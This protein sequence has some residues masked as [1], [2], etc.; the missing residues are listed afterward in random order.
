MESI[1]LSLDLEEHLKKWFGYNAFRAFQKEIVEKILQQKDVLAILPT[2]A[3]KSI[4]YQLPALL[5]EGTAIVI[6][7]LIS[8]MQDQVSALIKNGIPATYINSSLP[9]SEMH[10]ILRNLTSYKLVYIAPER[11][12]DPNFLERLK[13][14]PISFF[15]IDEAHCISQWGHAFRPDYRQLSL[16]KKTFPDKPMMALT[17]TA[18]LEVEKDLIMQLM[19]SD[20]Y[21]AKGSFDRPNLTIR[22]TEKTRAHQ[23][24]KEFLKNHKNQSGIIY[25]AT[26]KSVDSLYEELKGEEFHIGKYHAGMSD[27]ER[28]ASLHDFIHDKITLMVATVAFGMGINKPDVRFILHHDM[29]RTIEQY[30]QEIGRAGRDGLPAECMMLYS[31]QDLMIYKSFCKDMDDVELKERTIAKTE[32]MFSLCRSLKC[33]RAGLLNYFGEEYFQQ[34]CNGCDNCVNDEETMDGTLIAQKILSCVYRLHQGFGVRHVIDVLRGSKSSNVKKRGHDHISTYSLLSECSEVEVR[35]YIDS[36]L[37]LGLL[38]ISTGEYPVLQLTEASRNA[39]NGENKVEFRK[40]I[41]KEKAQEIFRE[42]AEEVQLPY[43][44]L[45]FDILR[46]LRLKIARDEG[47]PPF[48]VFSDKSLFE[49]STYFPH[50]DS[51]FLSINGVGHH[52]LEHYGTSFLSAIREFCLE[53][54]IAPVQKMQE[55][56]PRRLKPSSQPLKTESVQESFQLFLQG[57]NLEQIAQIRGCTTGTVASHICRYIES[58]AS[59]TAINI[60]SLVSKEHQEAIHKAIDTVGTER[61]APIKQLL[62]DEISYDE[63]RFVVAIRKAKI[64]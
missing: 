26:R 27:Q 23:Q 13:S 3:G 35:Y 8:L 30:Y 41:F 37:M 11:F 53:H 58:G 24:I 1:A 48:A 56:I 44:D 6:S 33:R 51:D 7:P 52:K 64:L 15:V 42:K 20:A 59:D 34:K 46:K 10:D 29:P 4:C 32:C 50:T 38:K 2:G 22:I 39:M 54:K 43:N 14:I 25:A 9:L 19:L 16:I 17:A 21:I 40:K 57:N 49:M 28:R 45:L 47:L 61:L 36:L 12:C 63:I 62:S 55:T 31:G 18:T 60:D 5:V